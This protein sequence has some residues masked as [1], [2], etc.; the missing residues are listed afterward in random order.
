M[1]DIHNKVSFLLYS[2]ND[3]KINAHVILGSETVWLSQKGMADVF[4][5]QRPAI[6]KH[7]QNIFSEGELNEKSVSS[8][9]EHTADD[10]KN[11]KTAFYNLDAIIAVGYRVNSY[12]ATQFRIWATKILKEYLV[13]GFALDDERLKQGNKLFG[14]DYFKELL[15]RIREIR[16]SE[17]MFYEKITDL[18]A[19]AV[20]YDKNDPQTHTFFAKV[21]NK[22]EFAIVGKTSAEII[23]TRADAKMPYMGLKTWKNSKKEGKVQK[24]DVTVA[25][26]YLDEGELRK[27]NV[28]VNMYLDYAEL[29]AERNKIM[30]MKDWANKLDAF[31]KFN[32][33]QIL[34]DAGKI[35]KTVANTF[36]ENEYL[37]FRVIQDKE[38][39]SDFNKYIDR[40]KQTNSLPTEKEMIIEET[41]SEPE[42]SFNQ[43]L[44]ALLSV[45][46]MPKE[47]KLERDKDV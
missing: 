45:P 20:D 42:S 12:K 30:T 29:Q 38:Y 36:A 34:T 16:A 24:C 2:G 11:Y 40:I 37:K 15:E 9:L 17:R 47:K 18:Y 21:Q 28:L 22:L 7:L 13:K 43:T 32:E 33:Y 23:R 14:K 5:V 25:K 6:T 19:T 26:N 46:P 8:I 39:K 31:L 4:G 3:G 35:S 44:K 27:L 1:I 10:G 41:K